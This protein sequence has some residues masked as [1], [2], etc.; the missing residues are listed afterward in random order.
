M[1]VISHWII[2]R[3]SDFVSEDAGI[4]PSLHV[5]ML[6]IWIRIRICL[7]HPRFGKA[8]PNPHQRKKLNQRQ[9]QDPGFA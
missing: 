4:E 7:D 5:A 3:P 2:Y 8:D 9:K 1:Y 6:G